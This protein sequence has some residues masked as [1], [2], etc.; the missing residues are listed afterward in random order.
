MMLATLRLDV[1]SQSVRRYGVGNN[2]TARMLFEYHGSDKCNERITIDRLSFVV[3][4]SGAVNIG[5]KDYSQVGMALYHSLAHRSHSIGIFRIR[6][7]VREMSVGIK[8]LAA[9]GVGT[10]R[11][12][13]LFKE[14]AIAIAGINDDVHA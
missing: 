11:T 12:E 14:S 4:D 13:H 2:R 6:N 10:K 9:R 7:M 1:V 3:D 8:E 5:V